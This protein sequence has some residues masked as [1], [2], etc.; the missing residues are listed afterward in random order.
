M[1]PTGTGSSY[2]ASDK[3]NRVMACVPYEGTAFGVIEKT[4]ALW[5]EAVELPEVLATGQGDKCVL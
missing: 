5:G 1:F 3:E 4:R 2:N